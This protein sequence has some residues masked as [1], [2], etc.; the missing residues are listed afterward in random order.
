MLKNGTFEP[1]HYYYPTF[2][3]YVA[4]ISSIIP[5]KAFEIINLI[6]SGCDPRSALWMLK[7]P[8]PW[9]PTPLEYIGPRILTSLIGTLGVYLTYCL[10]KMCFTVR[11]GLIAALLL[12][13]CMGYVTNSH[14]ATTDIPVTVMMVLAALTCFR[15]HRNATAESYALA[16][17]TI[18]LATSTKYYGITMLFP[19]LFVHI[20]ALRNK[21]IA[22]GRMPLS[23]AFVLIGFV[24]GTPYSLFSFFKFTGQFLQ[25]NIT[26]PVLSGINAP[27]GYISHF[28]NLI[29]LMGAPLFLTTLACLVYS[30]YHLL[31]NR[32]F[33]MAYLWI[34]FT[35]FWKQTSYTG[36]C[37]ARE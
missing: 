24:A 6:F 12:A 10:G 16:G 28:K 23:F 4:L 15:A 19:F 17:L 25:M 37:C 30:L 21:R 5:E 34:G 7:I 35:P 8:N 1:P 3:I 27:I 29:K 33:E 11:T 9:Q 32:K 2:F 14:F 22:W 36:W 26:G 18:G 13:S 31:K 20:I